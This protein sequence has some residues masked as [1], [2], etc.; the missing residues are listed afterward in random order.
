ML[1]EALERLMGPKQAGEEGLEDY[2]ASKQAGEED[3][4]NQMTP[5]LIWR[6]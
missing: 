4:E 2:M 5:S 1:I 3:S 6:L